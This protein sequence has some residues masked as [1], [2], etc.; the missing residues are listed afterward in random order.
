VNRRRSYIACLEHLRTA[1]KAAEVEITLGQIRP[2]A[3]LQV[4]ILV[5]RKSLRQ[6]LSQHPD[7][8]AD[9][10][11]ERNA[12]AFS[13]LLWAKD[14][15]ERAWSF[16]SP[17]DRADLEA[18]LCIIGSEPDSRA[19]AEQEGPVLVDGL[20]CAQADANSLPSLRSRS[21]SCS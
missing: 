7:I 19:T 9:S 20:S 5:D 10:L 3:M 12:E 8:V 4:A 13:K 2:L 15:L 1:E 16:L 21:V 18:P 17:C 11:I 6:F 14:N